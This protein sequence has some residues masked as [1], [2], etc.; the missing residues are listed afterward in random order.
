MSER[1]IACTMPG[2]IGDALSAVPA[3]RA[4]AEK[5]GCQA[6]FWTS[7]VVWPAKDLLEAQSFVRRV[8]IDEDYRTDNSACGLQPWYMANAE[9]TGF[10]Y[11]AVYHL[12]FRSTPTVPLVEYC[13][14]LYGIGQQP[15]RWDLPANRPGPVGSY[16]FV[17]LAAR[18]ESS[19]R[20]MF[21]EFVRRCPAP[22]VEVG[23]PGEAVATDL[24]ALDCTSPGFL[25]MAWVLS[26]CKWFVGLI[27]A[28]YVVASGFGCTKIM[29]HN[30][31]WD[32]RHVLRSGAH[33]YVEG[34]D[35]DALLR[36]IV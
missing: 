29:A 4:L 11:E 28:P 19:F 20:E 5:H 27:S 3:A 33:H 15:V 22:V 34:Y 9:N 12:G 25:D 17:A 30:S 7:P 14:S 23:R 6:D 36:Y 10:G 31:A 8:V 35:P 16:P 18:G 2:L 32:M 21:H 1:L 26:R 13:G 24:D